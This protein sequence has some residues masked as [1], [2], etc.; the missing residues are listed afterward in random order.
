MPPI[1]WLEEWAVTDG[2]K[3][4]S[5]PPTL[6]RGLYGGTN[7]EVSWLRDSTRLP[8]FPVALSEAPA[9]KDRLPVT[10][11]GARRGCTGVPGT[12]FVVVF[13]GAV[14]Y[15]RRP[16]AARDGVDAP[17]RRRPPPKQ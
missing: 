2:R 16:L 7:G 13:S 8:G 1:P 9:A 14:G 10:V 6:P 15:P 17:R 11:A 4:S 5:T 12:P 3:M